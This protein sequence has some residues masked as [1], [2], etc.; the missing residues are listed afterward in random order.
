ME[1]NKNVVQEQQYYEKPR[2][3]KGLIIGLIVTIVVIA[4]ALLIYAY[5][6]PT[7]KKDDNKKDENQVDKNDTK[8]KTADGKYTIEI[9]DNNEV[10]INKKKIVENSEREENDKYLK[11]S[12][13]FEPSMEA[14]TGL[15]FV[16]NKENQLIE[17]K[18]GYSPEEVGSDCGSAYGEYA[19]FYDRCQGF[20]FINLN[21]HDLFVIENEFDLNIY[22]PEWKEIGIISG[23][24]DNIK[25]DDTGLYICDSINNEN[26]CIKESKYDYNG[27]K[28]ND[29]KKET[30]TPIPTEKP[31]ITPT[32]MPTITP[33]PKPTSNDTFIYAG[34]NGEYSYGYAIVKG[35]IEVKKN[36]KYCVNAG[37]AAGAI[38]TNDAVIFHFVSTNSENF[39]KVFIDGWWSNSDGKIIRMGCLNN[40]KITYKTY[41]DEYGGMSNPMILSLSKD[42]TKKLLA[43][44]A[45]NPISLK[46]TKK[47]MTEF[48][49]IGEQCESKLTIIEEG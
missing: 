2:S 27:N 48:T 24:I 26:K 42:F 18:P 12:G 22:T 44:N 46:L 28:I 9:T 34:E 7:T 30:P 4:V 19:R 17:E 16:L 35:Y 33:T 13:D 43:S 11:I 8:Y 36:E 32:S 45:N 21:G 37:C 29:E 40:D 10:F 25:Y 39:K 20:S 47:K 38:T 6:E 3:N 49:G 15:S 31:V 14:I 23:D 5:L 1:E 41:A